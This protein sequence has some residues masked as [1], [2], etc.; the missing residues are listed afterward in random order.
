MTCLDNQHTTYP[1]SSY[2][3][4]TPICQR[5]FPAQCP[6]LCYRATRR[7]PDPDPSRLYL[8]YAIVCP[9]CHRTTTLAPPLL[10]S[11][12]PLLR[13]HHSKLNIEV[14]PS[15]LLPKA[16]PETGP[17]SPP[18]HRPGS[19]PAVITNLV[20]SRLARANLQYKAKSSPRPAPEE[21]SNICLGKDSSTTHRLSCAGV[22]V[23]SIQPH[24]L[25]TCLNIP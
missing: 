20:I 25:I 3:Q 10:G 15:T 19:A 17:P 5:N 4:H 24:G 14:C 22:S 12:N 13:Y 16:E 1:V 21:S 11:Q 2:Y 7:H 6:Y 23:C 8:S 9:S 18:V